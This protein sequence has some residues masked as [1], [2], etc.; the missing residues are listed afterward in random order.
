[1]ETLNGV[2][3]EWA[4]VNQARSGMLESGD[5]RVVGGGLGWDDVCE[6][7]PPACA[8]IFFFLACHAETGML[9]AKVASRH[10]AALLCLR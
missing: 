2:N 10:V 6:R 5:W 7:C 1:M 8:C 9:N 4:A 3:V